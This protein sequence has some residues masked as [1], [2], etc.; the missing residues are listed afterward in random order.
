MQL[1]QQDFDKKSKE[2]EEK[3]VE[4]STTIEVTK[5]KNDEDN[6]NHDLRHHQDDEEKK[7]LQ[8]DLDQVHSRVR[9]L[10][11]DHAKKDRNNWERTNAFKSEITS[12]KN[13]IE[14]YKST[15]D[16]LEGS[17]AE[18]Y[19]FKILA[20]Q[21]EMLKS[22][23]E[24]YRNQIKNLN[25]TISTMKIESDIL[26]NY[27]TKVL[28]EQNEQY[29]RRIQELEREHKMIAPLMSELIATLQKH[30]LTTTL[31]SDI[32]AY[33]QAFL[34]GRP[35]S[36]SYSGSDVLRL[37]SPAAMGRHK[38]DPLPNGKAASDN[39]LSA[40]SITPKLYR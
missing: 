24:S 13:E 32:E 29:L 6:A 21:N 4:L 31:K 11:E 34:Q 27:K 1:L 36:V 17:I 7:K 35:A 19:N 12:L 33:K 38:L 3:E 16:K 25:N 8:A 40:D 9:A 22:D 18:N 26:D 14:G 28:Q 23:V 2:K 37:G 39:T 5:R 10:E 20:E 30:G 15:I